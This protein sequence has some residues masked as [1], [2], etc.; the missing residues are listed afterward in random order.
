MRQSLYKIFG[1]RVI[2]LMDPYLRSLNQRTA[3][4]KINS[5][6]RDQYEHPV[7]KNH[8]FDQVLDWFDNHNIE[9]VNS[10]PSI[11]WDNNANFFDQSN[12]GRGNI[13]LRTLAQT[14]MI[15]G[16]L[17]GEGGLFIMIGRKVSED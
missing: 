7:E 11:D 10:I 16:K 3:E 8:T 9:F 2:M 1:K 6:I 13:F 12:S 5:W 15:F 14:S 17:G 4:R